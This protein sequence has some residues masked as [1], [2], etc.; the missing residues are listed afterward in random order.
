M[1]GD[2]GGEDWS[3]VGRAVTQRRGEIEQRRGWANREDAA[4]EA[5]VHET[6]WGKLERGGRISPL[7]AAAISRALE[8][9]PD[10]I[11][12]LAA[13]APLP[14]EEPAPSLQAQ[15]LE[16]LRAL[17]AEVERLR[18][19]QAELREAL[20]DLR[21]AQNAQP[22]PPQSTKPPR[23]GGQRRTGGHAG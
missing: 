9:P 14:W 17:V 4:R 3:R 20:T 23:R 21:Q 11:E 19:E 22:A 13:G 15:V 8:W 7:H 16:E 10:T 12:R 18:Q 5:G 1:E 2:A 6:T